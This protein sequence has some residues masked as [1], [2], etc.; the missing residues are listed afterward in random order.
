MN[1]FKSLK[2]LAIYAKEE[3][4]KKVIKTTIDM[5]EKNDKIYQ[6][7]IIKLLTNS[8]LVDLTKLIEEKVEN[9]HTVSVETIKVE[10]THNLMKR[11]LPITEDYVFMAR[12]TTEHEPKIVLIDTETTGL[13]ETLGYK[14]WYSPRYYKKYDKARVVEIGAIKCKWVN[15]QLTEIDRR[16]WLVK[17]NEFEIT[18]S[19]IHGITQEDATTN[20]ID[21]VDVLRQFSEWTNDC[22][23]TIGYNTGFDINI[24]L[25]E[26]FRCVPELDIKAL[27]Q[28]ECVMDLARV[29]FGRRRDMKLINVFN[30]LFGTSDIQSH[31]AIDDCVMTLKVYNIVTLQRC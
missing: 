18:N 2:T 24:I 23:K 27:K 31:N 20:G 15:N 17:P 26:K 11:K 10:D 21:I 13:P 5:V 16:R 4:A 3:I 8:F 7:P 22:D 1:T 25:S 14:K 6:Q 29:Y 30:E 28:S 19:H 12:T 9:E